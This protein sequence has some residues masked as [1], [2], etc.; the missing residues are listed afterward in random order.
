MISKQLLSLVFAF[1]LVAC[2][3]GNQAEDLV[4]QQADIMMEMAGI[5][6]GVENGEDLDDAKSELMALRNRMLVIEEQWTVLSKDGITAAA[7]AAAVKANPRMTE[8]TARY[9]QAMVKMV[10]NPELAGKV[11]AMMQGMNDGAGR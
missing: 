8:A 7:A 11:S 3:G 9:S 5:L 2:G 4:D 6:E 1:G 10:T